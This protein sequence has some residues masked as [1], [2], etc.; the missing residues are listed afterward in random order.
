MAWIKGIYISN[1]EETQVKEFLERQGLDENQVFTVH[2]MLREKVASHVWFNCGMA[3]P[4][5][6]FLGIWL[7]Y[8]FG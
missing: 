4:A 7:A 8:L 1:A 3:A 6:I 5:A 2:M